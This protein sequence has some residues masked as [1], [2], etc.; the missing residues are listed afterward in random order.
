MNE[1]SIADDFKYALLEGGFVTN[2]DCTEFYIEAKLGSFLQKELETMANKSPRDKFD[3][4]NIFGI[5]VMMLS[6]RTGNSLLYALIYDYFVLPLEFK[7]FKGKLIQEVQTIN[8]T[9]LFGRLIGQPPQ[10]VKF[11][12]PINYILTK[13]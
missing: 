2:E 3:A 11:N 10:N 5:Q 13:V 8:L 9:R 4:G 1:G 6:A 7:N 12:G